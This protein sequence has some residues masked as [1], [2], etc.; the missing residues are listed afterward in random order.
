MREYRFHIQLLMSFSLYGVR[1]QCKY[2]RMYDD[3]LN[4][5]LILFFYWLKVMETEKS[6]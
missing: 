5:H 3:F 6:V 2:D 4:Q 1:K